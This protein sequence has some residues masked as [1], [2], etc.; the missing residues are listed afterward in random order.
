VKEVITVLNMRN[1]DEE[2]IKSEIPGK[3]L[4]YRAALGVYESYEWFGKIGI[5]CGSGNNA[6]DG[7]A[8]ALILTENGY[9]VEIIK[10]KDKFSDDGLYYYKKCLEKGI[11]IR[12]FN[13]SLPKYDIN[14][15]CLLGPGFKGDVTGEL[16]DVINYINNSNS[17]VIS[18]DINS[19]LNGDNGMTKLAVK[20]DLTVSIGYIK[21]GLLLNMAKDYIKKLVNVDIGIK[22]IDKPYLLLEKEDIKLKERLNFSNK[23]TYGYVGIMGGSDNYPGAI[24]LANL[25]QTT[26]YSGAGVSRLI[27]PDSIYELIFN[28][29]LETTVFK[30][31]SSNGKMV[32]EEERLSESIKGLKVLG[33]GIGWDQS[34]DYIKILEFILNNYNGILVIDADGLN[35]LSKMDLN[36]LNSTKARVVLTPHLKEFSR[37]TG[38]DISHINN[39]SIELVSEFVKKYNVTLLLKGPTTIIADK[40]NL[41]L[42]NKGVS[43]MATAGSGD[44][45]TGILVGLLG[46]NN[47]DICYTVAMGSF[48]NGYAGEKAQDEYG[49]IGMVSSDTAR[50]ISYVLKELSE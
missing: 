9:E 24:R 16:K 19:G 17:I 3:T 43:G 47:D 11:K 22:A 14:V 8:L 6:G 35:T 23:G 7:Y 27:V 45:L 20:S 29:V 34:I 39:N 48:I 38:Y 21:P 31:P 40:Y 50:M 4:M 44:V 10:I 49:S 26:L 33:V 5:Y 28:N 12:P 41:Y 30:I 2:T 18:V 36:I 1:S 25:G 32:F 15:D 13:Q 46:H 37:L 42:V